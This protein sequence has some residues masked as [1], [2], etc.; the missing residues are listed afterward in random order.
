MSM[1]KSDIIE[2]LKKMEK[3]IEI[4]IKLNAF[5]G[6][7]QPTMYDFKLLLSLIIAGFEGEQDG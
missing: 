6:E 4:D 1:K 5:A 7:K 2:M 3:D